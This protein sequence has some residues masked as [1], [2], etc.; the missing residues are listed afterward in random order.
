MLT[1]LQKQGI[2]SPLLL[3][4]GLAGKRILRGSRIYLYFLILPCLKKRGMC[5]LHE[6]W[7]SETPSL[8]VT[9]TFVTVIS[10][11]LMLTKLSKLSKSM[12]QNCLSLCVFMAGSPTVGLVYS[13]HLL[14]GNIR[15]GLSRCWRNL[16]WHSGIKTGTSS[17]LICFL[18]FFPLNEK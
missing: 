2:V 17:T 11:V 1:Y 10:Y 7:F 12:W 5:S 9:Y 13:N 16:C 3:L 18:F 14:G 4:S 8:V 15:G 6:G